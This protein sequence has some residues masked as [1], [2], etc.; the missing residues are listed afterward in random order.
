MS[1]MYRQKQRQNEAVCFR[2]SV[3]ERRMTVADSAQNQAVSPLSAL[4]GDLERNAAQL[5]KQVRAS[6]DLV[7]RLSMYPKLM[8][9]EEEIAG[10]RRFR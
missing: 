2:K 8:R 5:R 4:I 3:F 10:L 1:G 7:W 6:T 9:L